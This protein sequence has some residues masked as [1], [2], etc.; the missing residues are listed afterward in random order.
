MPTKLKIPTIPL[1]LT[2]AA[3]G[4]SPWVGVFSLDPMPQMALFGLAVAAAGYL[5]LTA[6]SASGMGLARPLAFTIF[7]LATILPEYTFDVFFAWDVAAPAPS[8]RAPLALA[9]ITGSSRLMVGLAWPLVIIIIRLRGDGDGMRLAR[10][11]HAALWV[12]LLAALYAFTVYLKEF[13]SVL[14]TLL[15]LL[16]FVVYVWTVS[17]RQA[18]AVM[19]WPTARGTTP[20]AAGRRPA[21]LVCAIVATIAVTVAFAD[22]VA[23]H[24]QSV[25]TDQ[26]GLVQWFVPLVAKSPL[27]I[28]LAALAWSGR[29]SHATAALMS[30]QIGQLTILLGSLPVAFFV[31]GFL[32][33]DVG[34]L[35]LDDR[36][37]SELLL[38]AAQSLFTVMLLAKTTVSLKGAFA[39]LALFLLQA[40]LSTIQS[41]VDSPFAPTLLA[42][43]YVASATALVSRDPARLHTLLNMVPGRGLRHFLSPS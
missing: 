4:L 30:C 12:L 1:A 17:H 31:H 42:A 5:L 39:L 40:A 33:G 13:V 25:A 41:P 20:W 11:Q 9:A 21:V 29:A 18:R 28:I 27:L 43:V 15:L 10:D 16:L 3:L 38:A 26:F 22:A 35:P 34:S 19:A 6:A 14:D 7:V 36:Q 24:A 23:A 8:E 37:R 2:I 32:T